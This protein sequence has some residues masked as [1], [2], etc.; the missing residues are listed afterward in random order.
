MNEREKQE[1]DYRFIVEHHR[2][3]MI[4]WAVL[5][6]TFLVGIIELLPQVEPPLGTYQEILFVVYFA[7]LLGMCFSVLRVFEIY[8]EIRSLA[9]LR[10]LGTVVQNYADIKR[11]RFDR[12]IDWSPHSEFEFSIVGLS[13]V[14][15]VLLYCAKMGFAFL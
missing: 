13:L 6:F 12:I 8:R 11:T 1:Q 15:F 5:V 7:L 3:M 9:L 2:E 10:H 14:I 4:F